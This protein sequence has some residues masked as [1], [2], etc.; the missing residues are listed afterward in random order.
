MIFVKD[1]WPGESLSGPSLSEADFQLQGKL[2]I[3]KV[4][5]PTAKAPAFISLSLYAGDLRS[6]TQTCVP[7]LTWPGQ[8]LSLGLFLEGL[9]VGQKV[10]EETAQ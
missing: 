4:R 3:F 6:C 5:L 8:N 7:A 9:S 10:E 1:T 2:R